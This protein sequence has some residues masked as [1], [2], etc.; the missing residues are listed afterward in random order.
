MVFMLAGLVASASIALAPVSAT[1][2]TLVEADEFSSG[3]FE[4]LAGQIAHIHYVNVSDRSVQALLALFEVTADG[5]VRPVAQTPLTTV[6][7]GRGLS[8]DF[9]PT[10]VE[11]IGYLLVSGDT[12]LR[13]DIHPVASVQVIDVIDGQPGPTRVLPAVQRSH[14]PVFKRLLFGG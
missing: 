4:L 13:G 14:A 9:D 7:P 1:A 12:S 10:A 8:L 6:Q 3:P 11:L 2:F 5:S